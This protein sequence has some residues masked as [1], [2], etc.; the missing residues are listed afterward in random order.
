[1]RKQTLVAL[2]MALGAFALVDPAH[3]VMKLVALQGDPSPAPANPPYGRFRV[4]AV[5]DAPAQRIAA[6]S[7]T[8]GSDPCIWSLDPD[9]GPDGVVA[10]RNDPS[11]D[12][13]LFTVLQ[14][15]SINSAGE[16]AFAT[17][18]TFG[19]DGVYR[20]NP[21]TVVALTN[22]P[23]PGGLFQDN[24]RS[25]S[26]SDAGDVV[27]LA[28][29]TGGAAGDAAIFSCGGGDG[30]CS[31]TNPPVTATLTTLV[32][33][34][35]SLPAPFATYEFCSL[36]AVRASSFGIAFTAV[37]QLDCTDTMET[38][39]AGVFR[40]ST[41]GVLAVVALV[42][43]ATSIGPT[44]YAGFRGTPAIANVGDVSFQA[45]LVG[46]P[47]SALFRCNVATCPA[48]PATA[49]VESGELDINNNAIRFFSQP[50]VS[51]AGD[52]V[53]NARVSGG[54]AG[55]SNGVFV[56]RAASDTVEPI[57]MKNDPVPSSPGAVFVNLLQGP[58][59][60]SSGG[61]IAFKAKIKRP[62]APR[63]RIGLFIEE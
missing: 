60:I 2:W 24:H 50:S 10:C 36:T 34:G 38:P 42:G 11:P 47:T 6:Y 25:A 40:R 3:A 9:L 53:F 12:G 61:K 45:D 26:I 46:T 5:A 55:V 62:A 56:W 37:A 48:A 13:R 39:R 31:P 29:L 8:K 49:A 32:R 51:N 59:A 14:D 28:D 27:F 43:E 19:N 23:G 52:L 17:R 30:D 15:P 1:M 16:T 4:P 7:P 21:P 18:T 57:V 35:D 44:T 58:P 54:P 63:I 33:V 22:D 41:G 20:G